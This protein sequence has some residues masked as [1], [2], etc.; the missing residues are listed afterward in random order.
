M[1]I[2]DSQVV[3]LLA[4]D[5]FNELFAVKYRTGQIPGTFDTTVQV[6]GAGELPAVIAWERPVLEVVNDDFETYTRLRINGTVTGTIPP[7]P[8]GGRVI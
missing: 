2:G 1:N 7:P 5:L 8:P 4:V 3:L 6:P